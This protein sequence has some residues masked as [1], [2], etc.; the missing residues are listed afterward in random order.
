MLPDQIVIFILL[1]L[2]FWGWAR[3]LP[4]TTISFCAGSEEDGIEFEV[5][6]PTVREARA[7]YILVRSHAMPEAKPIPGRL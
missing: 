1:I 5:S 3:R 4:S 6:A 7:L 2:V